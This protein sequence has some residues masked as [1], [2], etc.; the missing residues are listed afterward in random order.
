MA[1]L[2]NSPPPYD[3]VLL[4]GK[5]I[6]GTG[7]NAYK[8]DLGIK[9]DRI[10]AIGEL[11]HVRATEEINVAGQCVAPGFIDTH[12]HDDQASMSASHM[13]PKISQGVTSVVVGNCGVSLAPLDHPSIVPEPINL[14]GEDE[15]FKYKDFQSYFDA[16]DSSRPSTNVTPLVG[17]SSLRVAAMQALDRLAQPGELE[18]MSQMVE[19]AMAAGASGMSTGV[20]YPLGRAADNREIVPLVRI[21][22]KFGGI[23]ASH[24]RNEHDG[25][26]DAMHEVFEAALEGGAPLLISHHKCAGVKNWGRSK[27]TMALLE[28]VQS[29]QDVSVDMYPYA[30][31]SSVLDPEL[32]DE[33]TPVLV[34]WSSPHPET[35]GTYLKEIAW[36]WGCSEREAARN[37][38]PAGACYFFMSEDDIE[39]I[40]RHP[41]TMIGS[42]GL[43]MDAHP[44]PRLWGTFPRVIRKYAV[45]RGLFSIEEA[46]R[47]MTSLPARRFRLRDR[48]SL[49]Q[50]NYAD[51]V[52]FDPAT[53]ADRATYEHPKQHAVGINYV[54]VNGHRSWDG[55]MGVSRGFGR[56]LRRNEGED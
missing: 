33:D 4:G 7:R 55:R 11:R 34:T 40:M 46:I 27:E 56:L 18:V 49:K 54:F 51:L 38:T 32:V 53:L 14:L 10:A 13:E 25:V 28:S 48:G 47:K 44:H 36:D 31:A 21:V 26:V 22:A 42:D 16:V 20:F 17:H 3:T 23:Y 24:M 8:S 12:T 52:V 29:K 19:E 1:T 43:P 41:S 50:G 6:D 39:H 15:H 9:G 30:A 2:T 37:L 35:A 45:E 5:L